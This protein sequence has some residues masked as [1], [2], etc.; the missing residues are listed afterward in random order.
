M[1]ALANTLIHA[2]DQV[3]RLN[4]AA[5]QALLQDASHTSKE[6][7]TSKSAEETLALTGAFV[8]PAAERLVGYS[9]NAFGI[10]SGIGTDLYKLVELQI[11][12]GKQK[13]G[14]LIDLSL[15]NAPPG[16]EA[17]VSFLKS[18]LAASNTAYDTVASA[19]KK[20]AELAQSNLAAMGSAA[21]DAVHSKHAGGA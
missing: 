3:V 13:L 7:L 8:Q 20:A 21:T 5:T 6:L 16:S 4:L 14:E 15:K 18:A 10:T 9:R 12:E 19:A 17:T 11:S 1:N 2:T